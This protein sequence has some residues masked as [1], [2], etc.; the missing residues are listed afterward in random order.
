M[1]YVAF[2]A[3]LISVCMCVWSVYVSKSASDTA[4]ALRE[5]RKAKLQIIAKQRETIELQAKF[6]Q[7]REMRLAFQ[8]E[9]IRLL[10]EKLRYAES[11]ARRR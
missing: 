6:L 4:K 2:F 7:D 11:Q 1:K 5:D 3:I 8:N 10:W 9:S